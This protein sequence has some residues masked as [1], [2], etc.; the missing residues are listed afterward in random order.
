MN[1]DNLS[2]LPWTQTL[3]ADGAGVLSDLF[4]KGGIMMLPI[5]LCSLI[6]ILVIV[7]RLL[8]LRYSNLFPVRSLE[9]LKQRVIQNPR[10]PNSFQPTLNSP[11]ERIFHSGLEVL[12][13]PANHF[14][15]AL[16][17]QARQ[18]RH[19]MERGLVLLEIVV[20][21]APLLGLLGTVLGMVDVFAN[22][23]LEGA[24]RA[25]S[26]SRGISEALFT[27]VSGLAVGIPALI[28]FNLFFRKI[29]SL[30]LRMEQEIMFL[31]HQMFPGKN[32]VGSTQKKAQTPNTK[33][34][35]S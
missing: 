12:P 19:Q 2:E 33:I 24:G 13:C 10:S 15:E 18:E 5:A 28:A 16:R 9:E 35:N 4:A 34:Q 17:D 7:E 29:D 20:G 11:V 1:S 8:V 23:S 22:L 25:E 21:I 14:K 27:T 32:T 6:M 26:L 31:Y 3:F 30:S